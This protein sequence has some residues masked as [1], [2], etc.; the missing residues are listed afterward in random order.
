MLVCRRRGRTEGRRETEGQME[1]GRSE[2]S[3]MDREEWNRI[4]LM[5]KEVDRV[6]E[7]INE[8]IGILIFSNV[9]KPITYIYIYIAT[10]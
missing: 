7:D 10:I 8:R 4:R 1:E 2:D 6:E 9:R 5:L 3:G